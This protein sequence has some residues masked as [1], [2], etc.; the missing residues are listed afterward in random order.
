MIV[1]QVCTDEARLPG[2]P[3]CADKETIDDILDAAYVIIIEN[4]ESY[5][6]QNNP[7]IDEIILQKTQINWYALSNVMLIDHVKKI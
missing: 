5:V 7:T 4:R 2:E 3:R 6:H 1:F